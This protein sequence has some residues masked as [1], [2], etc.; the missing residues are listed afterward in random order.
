MLLGLQVSFSKFYCVNLLERKPFML[1]KVQERP[2]APLFNF[3]C[4]EQLFFKKVNLVKGTPS[5]VWQKWLT[6]KLSQHFFSPNLVDPRTSTAVS[7]CQLN[8]FCKVA[9]T[10]CTCKCP[11]HKGHG[12][13][14]RAKR[15][16]IPST[17]ELTTKLRLRIIAQISFLLKL[18]NRCFL[19]GNPM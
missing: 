7:R 13:M 2:K 18:L 12:I 4:I 19:A 3:F 1:A 15:I 16:F 5:K 10:T 17:P 8:S 14:D 11:F 6:H 9:N